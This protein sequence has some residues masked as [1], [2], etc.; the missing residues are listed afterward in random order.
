MT[1][2]QK[3]G[4]TEPQQREMMEIA[5]QFLGTEQLY[6]NETEEYY[7]LVVNIK[8]TPN[9]YPLEFCLKIQDEK[10]YQVWTKPFK[11]KAL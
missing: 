9:L 10:G 6:R 4:F 5:R 7:G 2:L 1:H 3:Y 8:F 11:Q